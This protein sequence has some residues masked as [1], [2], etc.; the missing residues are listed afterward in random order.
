MHK[1]QKEF[2]PLKCLERV[3]SLELTTFSLGSALA[4]YQLSYTRISFQIYLFTK[5]AQNL[6]DFVPWWLNKWNLRDSNP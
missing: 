2:V 3:M 1:V 6:R 4:D 5:K